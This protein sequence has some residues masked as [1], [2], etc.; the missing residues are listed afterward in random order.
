MELEIKTILHTKDGRKIGNAVIIGKDG[1][2]WTVKTDYGNTL[3]MTSQEIHSFF[4]IAFLDSPD[5]KA[6]MEMMQKDHKH[7]VNQTFTHENNQ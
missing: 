3:K 2:R 7:L 4:H 5:P 6:V 1:Y